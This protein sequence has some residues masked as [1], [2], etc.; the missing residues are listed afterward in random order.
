VAALRQQVGERSSERG[1]EVAR[2]TDTGIDSKIEYRKLMQ[3]R[4]ELNA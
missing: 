2:S 1:L 3:H 4:H